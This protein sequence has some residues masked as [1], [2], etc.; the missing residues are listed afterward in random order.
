MSIACQLR[1]LDWAVKSPLLMSEGPVLEDLDLCQVDPAHL[2]A[3]LNA[4]TSRRVG[5][6][7]ERLILYWLQH[8]RAARIVAESLPIRDHQRTL[9]EI[10]FLFYDEREQFTHWET[11]V[12]FYLHYPRE[13]ASGSHYIGPNAADTFERKTARLLEQQLPLSE[14]HFPEV[15]VRQAF[16]KGRIF[17]HP[18]L[19]P[20][21]YQPQHLAPDHL[22][23]IWIRASELASLQEPGEAKYRILQKPFWLAEGTVGDPDTGVFLLPDLEQLLAKHFADF[24]Y[25][26]LISRLADPRQP[27]LK[28]T[29]IFVVSESW[30]EPPAANRT[31]PG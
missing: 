2:A 14:T 23:G 30:P 28:P 22:R 13:N 27:L 19:G 8:V 16:V 26:V 24:S 21:T 10:D 6:Y 9:G 3:F 18:H 29:H 20:P 11:A 4:V 1:D 5:R 15:A 25:P 7:F 31:T 17:Y 12:K